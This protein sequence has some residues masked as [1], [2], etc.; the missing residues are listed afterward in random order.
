MAVDFPLDFRCPIS[1][2]VMS[3]PVIVASGHTFDRSSIQ[4]WIDSG[5]RTCP[6]TMLPLPP[7]S[8]LIPN[9]ALRSLIDN[10]TAGAIA[11]KNSGKLRSSLS[12]DPIH[13]LSSLS[14]PADATELSSLLRLAKDSLAFRRLLADSGAPSILLRHAAA[15]DSPDLQDLSLRTL[16]YLSLDGDD[17][18]VGLVA[19]GALDHL[20]RVLQTGGPNAALAAT[21]LTSLAIVEVNKCTIGAHPAV[22]P[23][24]SFLLLNG[25]GRERREATTALYVLC[26][27]PDNRRRA[28]RAG[29]VPGLLCFISGGSE[30]AVQVLGLIAKCKEGREAMSNSDEFIR[31]LA[32]ILREGTARGIEHALLVLNLVCSDSKKIVWGAKEEGVK[33]TCL[34][35]VEKDNAKFGRSA[36]TL[37]RNLEKGEPV[38]FI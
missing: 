5:H 16:L 14:F 4:Q 2:E 33:D 21:T 9:Y 25:K 38:D 19:D 28:V 34:L 26:K 35:L 8:P 12:S 3:D 32:K 20:T 37:A 15:S 24:L 27:F 11:E 10:F 30:R 31:V 36:L 18:R 6:I 23:A 7:F 22:I 1:L 29:V 13:L 17:V